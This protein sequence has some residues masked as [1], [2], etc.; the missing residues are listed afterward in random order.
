MR[1]HWLLPRTPRF[2]NA[3][4]GKITKA[5]L[6]RH[7]VVDQVVNALNLCRNNTGVHFWHHFVQIDTGLVWIG[8][9]ELNGLGEGFDKAFGDI[10]DVQLRISQTPKQTNYKRQA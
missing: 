7:I 9:S 6:C 8:V 5:V 4:I 3:L 10:Q 1:G 2:L